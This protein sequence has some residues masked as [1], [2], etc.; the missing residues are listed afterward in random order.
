MT[1]VLLFALHAALTVSSGEPPAAFALVMGNNNSLQ[2]LRPDLRFADDDALKYRM[3]FRQ[4]MPPEHIMLLTRP[5]DESAQLMALDAASARPP[6][7][8]ALRDA[9]EQL[10]SLI[11]AA[12]AAGRT[13]RVYVVF[14][15]HGDVEKGRGYLE[16]EDG[17]L[18]REALQDVLTRLHADTTHLILDSCNSFFV[19]HPRRAG[20]R[21][22]STPADLTQGM[23][24]PGAELGVFLSTDADAQVYEWTQL[25]SGLFSHAVRSGLMGAADANQDQR[26]TYDELRAFVSTANA[27]ISNGLYRPQL[28]V[29]APN[30]DQTLVDLRGTTAQRVRL[31]GELGRA[32]LRTT[33]G[34]RLWDVHAEAGFEPVLIVT[35]QEDMLYVQRP[36]PRGGTVLAECMVGNQA[37][38][39]ASM[40]NTA[41]VSSRGAAAVFEQYF[42]IPFGPVAMTVQQVRQE[43]EAP[44]VFGLSREAEGRLL[45]QLTS[46]ADARRVQQL[47]GVLTVPLLLLAPVPVVVGLAGAAVVLAASDRAGLNARQFSNATRLEV[48]AAPLVLAT[49]VG[50][51]AVAL[52][53]SLVAQ[54]LVLLPMLAAAGALAWA[55]VLGTSGPGAGKEGTWA[56][57]LRNGPQEPRERAARLVAD[58]EAYEA[59]ALNR[60]LRNVVLV[61]GALSVAVASVSAGMAAAVLFVAIQIV[62]GA[63]VTQQVAGAVVAVG[64]LLSMGV[65]LAGVGVALLIPQQELLYA[66]LMADA[67]KPVDGEQP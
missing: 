24:V 13:T 10:S 6:T 36:S 4:L 66:R 2:L 32:T 44:P 48:T 21:P 18:T 27:G 17:P 33:H 39:D 58:L 5:D 26:I 7:H 49:L 55:V 61:G 30:H 1:P 56:Q 34:V 8:A 16:L 63:A 22:W 59:D 42:S 38:I 57:R 23:Q 40:L 67:V 3:L 41:E 19:V 52:A 14:A 43:E 62:Q 37:V 11:A 45:G 65:L 29:R 31:A 9:V 54:H 64:A 46:L 47:V 53:A 15:G 35:S 60:R 51:A 25:Q 20:G 28:F 12:R 50:G